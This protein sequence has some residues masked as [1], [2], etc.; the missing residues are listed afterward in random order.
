MLTYLYGGYV[1]LLRLLVRVRPGPTVVTD[2][3]HTPSVTVLITAHNEQAGISQRIRNVLACDYPVDRLTILVASDGSTDDTDRIVLAFGEPRVRLFRPVH[4]IG[5]TETQN[6]AIA[7]VSAN[8]IVF[9]DA[10]TSFDTGFLRAITRPF[11]DPAVGGVDGHLL[12][13]REAGAVAQSQGFYWSQELKIRGLE[14]RLGWLT[15]A[16]GA[17]FAVRRNLFRPMTA[18]VGEDC[19]IPLDVVRQRYR[20]VHAG[21][22]LAFDRMPS[23]PQRE[24]RTR[25]RMTLRNWQGTWLYPDLLNPLRHPGVAFA[26]WSH[27]VLRWLSPVFLGLWLIPGVLTLSETGP[28]ITP[29]WLGVMF[30]LAG[31]IG[32][33]TSGREHGVPVAGTV[34]GFFLANAGFAVGVFR[35]LAGRRITAYR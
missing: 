21:D 33:A 31:T 4:R 11:A 30:M 32:W 13:A 22:A 29:G 34:Y 27:K 8:I 1:L 14:S 10:D 9:T 25:A 19:L 18:S 16:S 7:T 26:L 28:A 15:V 20:M 24:F 3:D 12:F 17:C 2:A 23:E 6:H 35:A 5:K